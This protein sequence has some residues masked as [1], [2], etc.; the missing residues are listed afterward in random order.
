MDSLSNENLASLVKSMSNDDLK[1]VAN[2]RMK[3][4]AENELNER[5]LER[6]IPHLNV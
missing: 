3:R 1:R 5:M 2:E 6:R 4:A